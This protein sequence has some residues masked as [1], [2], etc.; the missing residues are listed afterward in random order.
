[1]SRVVTFGRQPT[2]APKHALRE[3]HFPELAKL[4]EGTKEGF[5]SRV[6]TS[7]GADSRSLPRTIF[8]Q[9]NQGMGHDG[10]VA[11]GSIHE[12]T[13]DGETGILS[14]KGWLLDSEDGRD[15]A[16]HIAGQA[17]FHNSVDLTEVEVEIVDHGDFWDD[18]FWM[19]V[20]FTEWKLGATTLVGKPAF[21]DAHAILPD[22]IKAAFDADQSALLTMAADTDH[23]IRI[24]LATSDEEITA[25]AEGL[26]PWEMF[27]RP[28][29][30]ESHKI[31]VGE[32][33]DDGWVPVY[34]HLGLWNDCHDGIEGRCV[35]IPRPV[36]NY[37]SFNQ[38]SVLT[39]RGP[40]ES[41]P[42]ALYGGHVPLHKAADD[43]ANA[44]ADVRVVAGKHGPWM[45]GVVRPHVSED[46]AKTYVA[47]ASKTSGHWKNGRL[48]MIVSCNTEAYNTPGSGFSTNADGDI[49]DLVASYPA[50]EAGNVSH[51][52]ILSVEEVKERLAHLTSLSPEER[53][54][55]SEML[56]WHTTTTNTTGDTTSARARYMTPRSPRVTYTTISETLEIEV[57]DD[58]VEFD[59]E[60]ERMRRERLLA[61]HDPD[62]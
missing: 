39:D 59:V 50:C 28:E 46:D 32:P 37:A 43:P 25:S 15:A 12:M 16:L 36:D 21:A 14:G 52:D 30:E 56:L 60:V 35:I 23:V 2:E 11:V 26:A 10:S 58:E 51:D 42:V 40:V 13:V 20:I 31:W 22:E 9:K 38:P 8:F 5:I 4:D 49:T 55:F 24:Q 19:E 29:S 41:G 53:Q 61:L 45:S 57:D 48:R 54:A 7:E 27:H 47:R 17:L 6:L 44:W 62:A 33:N 18:D 3:I 34:G 1:M